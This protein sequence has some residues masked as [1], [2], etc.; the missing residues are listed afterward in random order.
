MAEKRM[1]HDT[2]YIRRG[3]QGGCDPRIP[4]PL[5]LTTE[6]SGATANRKPDGAQLASGM[7]ALGA[8]SGVR[9][10]RVSIPALGIY[11]AHEPQCPQL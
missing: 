5:W 1:P 7:S 6:V 11:V 2:D 10:A 3:G 4:R 9:R 8:A